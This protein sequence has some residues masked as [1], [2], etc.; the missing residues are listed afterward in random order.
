M[1]SRL[2]RAQRDRGNHIQVRFAISGAIRFKAQ[3]E[4]R[5]PNAFA[6]QCADS[7]CCMANGVGIA[8]DAGTA[9]L[10]EMRDELAS[11]RKVTS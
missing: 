10:R 2:L 11:S 3:R 1:Y 7:M 4:S 9:S 5:S 8:F 6:V